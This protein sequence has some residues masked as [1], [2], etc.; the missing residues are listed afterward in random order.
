MHCLSLVSFYVSNT[1]FVYSWQ[2]IQRPYERSC[3]NVIDRSTELLG[4]WNVLA[5][6]RTGIHIP[7]T[8][9]LSDADTSSIGDAINDEPEVRGS[10]SLVFGGASIHYLYRLLFV[11]VS[12]VL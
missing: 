1:S 6:S 4:R 11:R 7:T 10:S 3:F 9:S 12:E 2:Q 5:W 8:Y